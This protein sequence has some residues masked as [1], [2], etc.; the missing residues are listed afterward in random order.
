MSD[1]EGA[2][3]LL[4]G[5]VIGKTPMILP[6]TNVGLPYT[7]T[8]QRPGYFAWTGQL[9]VVPGRTNLRVELFA[10]Q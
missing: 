1:P 4:N 10:A 8:I 5:T 3:V 7:L 2:D 6:T 9:V